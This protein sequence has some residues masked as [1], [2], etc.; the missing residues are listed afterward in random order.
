MN[1]PDSQPTSQLYIP[2]GQCFRHS[3]A[4]LLANSGA[5][6]TIIKGY[7]EWKSTTVAEGY[8]KKLLENK[9]KIFC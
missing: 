2:T 5:N 3:G 1:L 9:N 4:T 8:I 7:D 6:L